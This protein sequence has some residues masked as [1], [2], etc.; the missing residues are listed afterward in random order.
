MQ[1]RVLPVNVYD[2]SAQSLHQ[3]AI[4][5][6]V[7]LLRAGEVVGIPT[8]TVYGL[9]ADATNPVALAK[10]FAAKGR[11]SDHPLIVHIGPHDSVDAWAIDI[12][13]I[14]RT[15]IDTFWPGPLTLILKR[16]AR[17]PDA[18]TGG[19]DTVGLRCPSH[20]VAQALLDAF[21]GGIAA[22][23]AN[24]FGKISPTSAQDVMEELGDRIPLILDGGESDKGIES[25]IV[26]VSRGY[27]V[28]LRPGIISADMLQAVLGQPV[29]RPDQAAPRVSGSLEQHYAPSTRLELVAPAALLDTV[30]AYLAMNIS[31]AVITWTQSQAVNAVVQGLDAARSAQCKLIAL[32]HGVDEVAHHL[33]HALREADHLGVQRILIEHPPTTVMWEGVLDRLKRAAAGSA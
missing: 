33:Y 19:Q 20:P 23:S 5:Q 26:D 29:A 13:D 7:A 16:S 1:A 4:A 10:I 18:V 17:V 21:G 22:P 3:D 24:R 27:P 28:L 32:G 30:Q 8:E 15:L 25:T 6:A 12:P 14:A 9:G 31:L 2:A 11:P